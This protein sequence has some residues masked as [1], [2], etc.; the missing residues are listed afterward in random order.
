M[1]DNKAKKEQVHNVF[2]NISGKYDRLNNIISF[3]QHK[4]WRKRVMKE[5]NVKPG[6]KALDV[7]CGTADW[8]ISLSKAVGPNGEV[9]GV[10]FSENMLEVGKEKTKDMDNIKLVHGDAMNL[11][12]EDNEFDYVTIGFGLRN[13]P[14]YLATLKELNRVLK[15]GGMVVCLETSQPTTPVFKQLYKLYF[16]FVMP[17]FGKVFAKSKDEYEW[18]QQSTFD[19]PGKEKLKRLFTQAGFSNIKVRSFTGGVAAMHLGYK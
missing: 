1:A 17:I 5:M 19:F 10:D 7:C 15:P 11:P 4:T 16:K 8:S 13:V 12:F 2:Q 18:L 6:S 3:E 9:T 14:D